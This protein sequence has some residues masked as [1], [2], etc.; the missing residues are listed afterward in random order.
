[1][2]YFRCYDSPVKEPDSSRTAESQ[3]GICPPGRGTGM[4]PAKA[5]IPAICTGAGEKDEAGGE[6]T[7][8]R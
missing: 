4:D 8:E 3:G 6:E 5:D 1:M 2:S 7:S